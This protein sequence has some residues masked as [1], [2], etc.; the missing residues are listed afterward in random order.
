MKLFTM[1][2]VFIIAVLIF[3]VSCSNNKD[4]NANNTKNN[5]SSA[6]ESSTG[7]GVASSAQDGPAIATLQ[8]ENY[9]AKIH[10]AIPFVAKQDEMGL[11]KVKEGHQYIVWIC[12]SEIHLIN[13]LKWETYFWKQKLKMRMGEI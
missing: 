10:R 6:N 4:G 7:N 5:S 1:N 3:V 2:K 11:F 9:T 13:L 12:P 8:T